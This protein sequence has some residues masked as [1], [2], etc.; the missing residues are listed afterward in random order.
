MAAASRT[1]DV[2]IQRISAHVP[3]WSLS[4]LSSP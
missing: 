2:M 4:I 1:L 3:G